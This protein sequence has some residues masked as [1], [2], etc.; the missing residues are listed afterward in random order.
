MRNS[1]SVVRTAAVAITACVVCLALA[2][3][4][5]GS[6]QTAHHHPSRTEPTPPKPTVVLLHGAWADGSSWAAVTA[7]LQREGFTVDVVPNPLRGV[8]SDA[9]YLRDYLAT[10]PGKIVLVGHSYGGMVITNAAAGNANVQ[11]LVYIDAFIPQQGDTVQQLASAQPGSALDPN[12][13][14]DAVPIRDA[15]G[16]VVDVDLYVKPTLFRA[17]FAADSP[18]NIAAV[19]AASQRPETL[20]SLTEA[21]PGVPA[22]ET[23]PSWALIG[24]ADRVIP[25][26]EQQIMATRAHA[27]VVKVRAPHLA[28]VSAPDA[29]AALIITAAD[30]G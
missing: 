17:L 6:A 30:Q 27:H 13:A 3:A 19:L 15:S 8:A 29:V 28:M 25:P 9:R 21:F 4:A 20:S 16:N 23:I 10:V 24:T 26:A 1:R 2:G 11:A 12:T 7:K 5:S 22:W 14:I 18:A